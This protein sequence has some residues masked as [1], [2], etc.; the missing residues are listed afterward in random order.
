MAL[1]RPYSTDLGGNL[2]ATWTHHNLFG[3]AEQLVLTAAATN[4]GGT[5]SLQPGYNF[6]PELT[7]PDWRQRGQSLTFQLLGVNEWLQAYTAPPSVGSVTLGRKLNPTLTASVG[8]SSEEA[9]IVQEDVGRD[10]TLLAVPLG[11]RYDTANSRSTRPAGSAPRSASRPTQS[12]NAGQD[13]TFV[14]AQASA[15]TYLDFGRIPARSVL[16]CAALVG[17]VEGAS[18]FD[19]PPDQRFYA[20][21]GGTVRGYRF[22]SVGPAIRRQRPDRRHL[23]RRRQHRVAPAHRGRLW[24][25]RLRR[26]RAGRHQRRAVRRRTVRVG[27]GVGAR[28]Y[29]AFGPLRLDVAVPLTA[30]PAAMRSKLYIGI[31]QAF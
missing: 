9:H 4:L 11:L 20:G 6:R 12:F 16:A 28:Y 18:T 5:A 29:T 22:Q 2:S 10:Y 17:G 31:G 7:V 25:G 13:S 30:S 26:C 3:N 19:I 27:A 1:G 23:G 21:G 24:R 14:I 8:V 15:S